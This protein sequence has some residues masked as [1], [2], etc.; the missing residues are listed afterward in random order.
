MLTVTSR[1][2]KFSAISPNIYRFTLAIRAFWGGPH[3][4]MG[5]IAIHWG[6]LRFSICD[7]LFYWGPACRVGGVARDEVGEVGRWSNQG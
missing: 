2:S 3:E 7:R 5:V 1:Y 6:H 4:K